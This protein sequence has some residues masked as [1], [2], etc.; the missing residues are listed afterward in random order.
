MGTALT[1]VHLT[2]HRYYEWL[3]KPSAKIAHFTRLPLT[4]TTTPQS[5]PLIFFAGLWDTVTYLS[6]VESRYKPDENAPDHKN[7][8][9]Y[10]TGNPI[11]LSTFTIMTTEPAADLRWLHDRMPCVLTG[12]QEVERW[13]DSG[14]WK[15]GKGGTGELLRSKEGLDW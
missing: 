2:Y 13:L 8:E 12:W 10:P 3:K 5:P 11:P 9:A 7:R 15:E 4:P 14:G 1:K 6:P